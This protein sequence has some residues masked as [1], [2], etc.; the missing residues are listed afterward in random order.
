MSSRDRPRAFSFRAVAVGALALAL[1][2]VLVVG[3]LYI[4]FVRYERVAVH[5]I[6]KGATVALRLD[7]QQAVLYEP[8]RR[9][10]LPLL[11]GPSRP[12]AEGDARVLAFERRSGIGRADLREVVV[13]RGPGPKDW[14][15]VL[16]GIFHRTPSRSALATELA[17]VDSQWKLGQDGLVKYGDTGL[18]AADASDGVIIVASSAEVVSAALSPVEPGLLLPVTGAG[19][20]EVTRAAIGEPGAGD[21]AWNPLLASLRRMDSLSGQI[22]LDERVALALS[23]VSADAAAARTT[24][25]QGFDILRGFSRAEVSPFAQFLREGADRGRVSEGGPDGPSVVLV[26]E[27]EELDRA[28]EAAADWI[29]AV[30]SVSPG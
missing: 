22:T 10:L 17:A 5:H 27:R 15:I 11:G 21:G 20:F 23:P 4:R 26:W 28:F 12:P 18:S 19:G 2:I 24:A 29:R 9:H 6:P 14:A 16:G 7:V 13:F 1:V 25:L 3:F 8:F 30:G